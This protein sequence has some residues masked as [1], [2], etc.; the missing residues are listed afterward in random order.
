VTRGDPPVLAALKTQ[1]GQGT[2]MLGKYFCGAGI[3]DR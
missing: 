2:M 1:Y 3:H